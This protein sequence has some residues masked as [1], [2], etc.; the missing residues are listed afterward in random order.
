M[1]ADS[2]LCTH[3]YTYTQGETDISIFNTL[4]EADPQINAITTNPDVMV[5]VFAPTNTAFE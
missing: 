4:V 2:L 3:T 5:T 1:N